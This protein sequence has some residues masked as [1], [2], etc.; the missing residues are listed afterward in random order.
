MNLITFCDTRDG[1]PPELKK[2]INA[3]QDF[4]TEVLKAS[5]KDTILRKVHVFESTN[6]R[7]ELFKLKYHSGEFMLNFEADAFEAF[8][9]LLTCIHTWS[10]VSSQPNNNN[11]VIPSPVGDFNLARAA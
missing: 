2:L 8:D 9:F 7:R 3:I 1:G 6:V 11:R 10:Q 4:Y 5:E